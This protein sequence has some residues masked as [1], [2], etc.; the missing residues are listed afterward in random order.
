MNE[1]VNP[2]IFGPIIL[3]TASGFTTEITELVYELNLYESIFKNT[4]ECDI[5]I[6]DTAT[7]RLVQKGLIAAKD[8][9]KFIFAGKKENGSAEE[10]ISLTM[11]VYKLE[12][13]SPIGQVSQRLKLYLVSDTFFKNKTKDISRSYEGKITKTIK[14]IATDD[15]QIKNIKIETATQ[16]SKGIYPYRSPLEIINM[17]LGRISPSKNPYD[18]NYIFYETVDDEF[19]LA[20][21][22][23]MMKQ[24]PK[25]GNNSTNG[26]VITMPNYKLT[27]T[28]LKRTCLSHKSLPFSMIE[29]AS[30][31]MWNSNHLE[32]DLNKKT[33][34]EHSFCY[35]DYFNKQTHLSNNK[36][37]SDQKELQDIINN[38]FVSRYTHR[39]SYLFDYDE[40]ID[41]KTRT[42][43]SDD[44]L[45][46]R[47]SCMEQL[48]QIKLIFSAPGNSTLR[49]GD[50]IYFGRPIEQYLSKDNPKKDIFYNGKFLIT[51]IKHVL[52]HNT[53]DA[54]FTY[55]VTIM[56]MK[57]SVGDE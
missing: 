24:Q 47:M 27:K 33:Y 53:E 9:I 12:P 42:D 1:F 44:W 8:K 50:V 46:K 40:Q 36:I 28:D 2:G 16:E 15:L 55:T 56:C 11:K 19:K 48:N 22:G 34:K 30:N 38:T 52:K 54:G 45:L 43:G 32:F 6:Q 41:K 14:N 17:L 3:T 26:F 39:N 37:V 4:L 25:V 20:S 29:N 51:T 35:N 7:T 31:G 21:I 10:P 57:D 49:A 5:T 23:T 13:G 18:Y